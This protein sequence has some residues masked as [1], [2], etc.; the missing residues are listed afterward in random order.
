M[1]LSEILKE[2]H[3]DW[4]ESLKNIVSMYIWVILKYCVFRMPYTHCLKKMCQHIFCSVSVKYESISITTF[5]GMSWKKHL[6]KLCKNCL[7]P[8][9]Y[10]PA[11][12]WEIWTDRL[13]C[14]HS[15]YM[16]ILMN[17]RI[18]TKRLVVAVIVSKLVRHVVRMYVVQKAG[19]V[20]SVR[21]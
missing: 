5:S 11:L 2:R 10:V 1:K 14:K 15:T 8:L 21:R 16:Y 17:H 4:S 12:P 13:S 9:K 18:A 7:L 20:H 19:M 3:C 6:T